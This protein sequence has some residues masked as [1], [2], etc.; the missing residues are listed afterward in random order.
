MDKIE[1]NGNQQFCFISIFPLGQ[2]KYHVH[3][4][5]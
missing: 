2:Q 3:T 5:L 1:D 4:V